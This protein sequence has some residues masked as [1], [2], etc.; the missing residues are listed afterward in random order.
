[1]GMRFADRLGTDPIKRPIRE[2]VGVDPRLNQRWSTR[3]AHIETRC[4]ELAIQFQHDHGRPPTPVEA[5]QLAQQATLETRDAKHEP[6]SQAEQ[7][8]TWYRE[9]A[10]VLGSSE[11]VTAM[12]RRALT[13]P[14]EATMVADARWVAQTADHILAVMEESRSTWQIWHVRAEAQ[15]QV[16]TIDMPAEHTPALVQLLVEEVVN[17]RSTALVPPAD[18]IEDR[19]RYGAPT[20]RRSTPW[21]APLT[22]PRN[23]SSTPR[24][25]SSPR[26]HNATGQPSTR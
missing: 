9:A 6:R 25:A 15:R 18:H 10:A 1:L 8:T 7:R 5:L 14:A 22:T 12:V 16:R 11:A 21:P 2:I 13:P 24:P 26:P 4:G 23:G 20:A 17:H 19:T 3:R